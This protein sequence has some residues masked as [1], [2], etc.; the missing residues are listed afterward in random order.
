MLLP[1]AVKDNVSG[2]IALELHVNLILNIIVDSSYP[3]AL[4][5]SGL[6][7]VSPSKATLKE[8]GKIVVF[9]LF[10]ERLV[11]LKNSP[12]IHLKPIIL[13]IFSSSLHQ[14][15]KGSDWWFRG[16]FCVIDA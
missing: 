4:A 15:T 5:S 7:S 1:V 13:K 14:R 10:N 12:E 16:V 9:V 11:P 6:S 8:K 3:A 2:I